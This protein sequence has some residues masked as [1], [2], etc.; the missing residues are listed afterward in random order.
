VRI[1]AAREDEKPSRRAVI[2]AAGALPGRGAYL[3]RLAAGVP[4][5]DCLRRAERSRGIA[6]GLRSAVT[7]E[8]KLVESAERVAQPAE[9]RRAGPLAISKS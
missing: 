3:C 6:R 9:G 5:P 4:D 7:L 1:V 8:L 2:D